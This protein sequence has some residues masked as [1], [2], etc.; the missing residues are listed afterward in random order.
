MM[1][2]QTDVHSRITCMSQN[3]EFKEMFLTNKERVYFTYIRYLNASL[4]VRSVFREWFCLWNSKSLCNLH[5][6][7]INLS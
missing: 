4:L 6:H 1:S 7:K 2:P 3:T 5:K